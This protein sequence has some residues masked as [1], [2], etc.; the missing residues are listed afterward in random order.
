MND[1]LNYIKFD[2]YFRS[3]HHGELTFSLIYAFSEN[4]ILVFSHDEVVHGKGTLIGKMP[5]TREQRFANLRLTYA[6]LFTHPGK[7][8]LFMGQDLGEFDEW[9]EKRRVEWFLE[10]VPEHQGIQELMKELNGLYRNYPALHEK[11]ESPD[12][13]AWINAISAQESYLA[14]LRLTDVP[15]EMLLVVANFSGVAR[16]ITVGVPYEG[17]Y[18]EILNTDDKRFGGT[19]IINS[20]ML[21]AN[22]LEWDDR[23]QSITLNLAPL[24][25]AIFALEPYTEEELVKV[26]EDRIRNRTPI[27]AK[28][29]IGK[30]RETNVKKTAATK[31]AKVNQTTK[32]NKADVES[33][34]TQR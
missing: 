4:F 18:R 23:R 12:G 27:K 1:Y 31:T 15:E 25:A 32:G 30:T 29:G 26:I 14:Y 6:Y 33:E 7:K 3:H 28:K 8:L 22:D 13:F 24:S 20:E 2:P 11:D 10:N 16:E 9:N 19:G 5:G 34:T 17:K 21:M